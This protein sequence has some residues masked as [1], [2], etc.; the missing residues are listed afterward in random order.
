MSDEIMAKR[1]AKE[2]MR[3]LLWLKEYFWHCQL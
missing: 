1:V 2:K 3:E